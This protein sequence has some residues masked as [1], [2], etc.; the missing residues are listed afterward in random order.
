SGASL[1]GGDYFVVNGDFESDQTT[2]PGGRDPKP[3]FFSDTQ[4]KVTPMIFD[5]KNFKPSKQVVTPMPFQGDIAVSPSATLLGARF[6]TK[7]GAELGYRL[8]FMKTAKTDAGYTVTT[9]EAG[10]VCAKGAK[11]LFSY[12]E[13][14]M[15][16]HHF[17]DETDFAEYG[18]ASKNDPA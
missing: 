13:R 16:V 9:E 17:A 18:F 14:F 11:P 1:N 6:G 8:S 3:S 10:T 15:V 7:D 5:G 4:L 12:D 2:D